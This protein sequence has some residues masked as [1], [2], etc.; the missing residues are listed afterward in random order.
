M[1]ISNKYGMYELDHELQFCILHVFYQ[2]FWDDNVDE[3][4]E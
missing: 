4:N 2:L 3:E 1:I